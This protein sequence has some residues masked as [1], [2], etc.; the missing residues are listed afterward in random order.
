MCSLH[1]GLPLNQQADGYLY[2]NVSTYVQKLSFTPSFQVVI[3]GWG[4]TSSGGS[5]PT[6]LQ[7]V[8]HTILKLGYF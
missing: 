3:S 5:Q 6:I 8:C 4:T 7:K 1:V 2:T